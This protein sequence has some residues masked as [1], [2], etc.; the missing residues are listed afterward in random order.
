MKHSWLLPAL[1]G[2]AQAASSLDK[3]GI[4]VGDKVRSS[5]G[6]VL[7]GKGIA[8]REQ[9]RRDGASVQSA[10]ANAIP[11]IN[12]ALP[13]QT[14]STLDIQQ[15]EARESDQLED[16]DAPPT[17]TFRATNSPPDA[18][19]NPPLQQ[20]EPSNSHAPTG[21]KTRNPASANQAIAGMSVGLVSVMLIFT[22]FL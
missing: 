14:Q 12:I 6:K 10:S 18:A 13:N 11:V 3:V 2:S 9:D 15:R 8:Y 4:A 19:E 22:V 7:F 1:L 16:E 17:I 21:V 20:A 5:E